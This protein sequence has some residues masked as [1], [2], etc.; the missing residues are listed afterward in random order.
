M[1]AVSSVAHDKNDMCNICTLGHPNIVQL[2]DV[3][4]DN[5]HVYIIMELMAG[6]ELFERI[7]RKTFFTEN[8]ARNHMHVLTKT[9][10]YLHHKSIVHRDLKPEVCIHKCNEDY[11]DT[12]LTFILLFFLQNLL[13]EDD[14]DDAALK[15]V[16]FGFAKILQVYLDILI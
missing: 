16:D 14:S 4:R 1:S 5:R 8:E 11:N 12:N 7:K 2:V 9:V 13:F 6:G 3:C 10:R 15:L